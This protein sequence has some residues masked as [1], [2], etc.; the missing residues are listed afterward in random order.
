MNANCAKA[1]VS[2]VP[3]YH[4]P[5][6]HIEIDQ[7]GKVEET[8]RIT[9][10][11]FSNHI[12]RAVVIPAA[13]KRECIEYLRRQG[14]NKQTFVFQIFAAGIFCLIEEYLHQL[15]HVAIDT[16]YPGRDGDIKG[17][18]LNAILRVESD[19]PKQ[20]ISFKQVG[21]KSGCHFKAYGVFTGRQKA[22]RVLSVED[23]LN[24]LGK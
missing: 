10:I 7:S 4:L 2:F 1:L 21:K 22:D 9:V 20:R 13:V 24:A 3:L 8:N 18:L 5:S 12:T 23:I 6:M 19:F 11:A 17:M 14:R 15:E 16:E